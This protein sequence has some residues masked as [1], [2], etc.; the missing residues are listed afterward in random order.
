MVVRVFHLDDHELF[1]M[2]VQ[3]LI[4]HCEGFELVGQ[5]SN[6]DEALG[7]IPAVN[8]DIAI[9]DVELGG[10]ANGIEVC[11]EIRA[12]HPKVRCLVLTAYSDDAALFSA[13]MAGASGYLLKGMKAEALATAL[14]QV[15][16][17]YSLLDPAVTTQVLERLRTPVVDDEPALTAQE[18]RVLDLI[19]EGCTNREIGE[20]L[21][22]AEKTV[23]NYVSNVLAK[24][25]LQRR[26]EAAAY[27]V[28]R[29]HASGPA[30]SA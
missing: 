19:A 16:A 2:G 7:R 15:A 6:A 14:R 30:K 25:G 5:A 21:Y 18:R 13:I 4:E 20:R 27:A 12:R 8:P 9:L 17:G 3:T 24:L 26:S 10:G 22:L 29:G 23:R 11:R 28:R 1:R